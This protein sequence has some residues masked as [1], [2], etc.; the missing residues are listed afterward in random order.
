MFFYVPHHVLCLSLCSRPHKLLQNYLERRTII[1]TINT[2]DFIFPLK[3]SRTVTSFLISHFALSFCR[4]WN[5]N[6]NHN[7]A[8]WHSIVAI[9]NISPHH[10]S[11]EKVQQLN[12]I[13]HIKFTF[14]LQ[15]F[16]WHKIIACTVIFAVQILTVNNRFSCVA[17]TL[18]CLKIPPCGH[19]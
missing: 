15:Y 11:T 19:L 13:M 7:I 12:P 5:E 14:L 1:H 3:K 2:W 18:T 6:C 10:L 16:M 4:D 8:G 17:N 9:L